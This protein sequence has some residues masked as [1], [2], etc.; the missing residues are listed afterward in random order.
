MTTSGEIKLQAKNRRQES[1]DLGRQLIEFEGGQGGIDILTRFVLNESLMLSNR[2][3][4]IDIALTRGLITIAEI[5]RPGPVPTLVEFGLV[6]DK[7][8]TI[9]PGLIQPDPDDTLLTNH[10]GMAILAALGFLA[11]AVWEWYETRSVLLTLTVTPFL[12][13]ASILIVMVSF[14]ISVMV[15][16]TVLP[17][18]KAYRRYRQAIERHNTLAM[19]HKLKS[20]ERDVRAYSE[21]NGPEFERLVARAFRNRGWQV[22]EMGGAND[23]GIDLVAHK[24]QI[25]AVVQCKAHARQIPPAVVRELYGTFRHSDASVAILAITHGPSE[26]A[27][28][29]AKDKPIRFMSPDDLIIGRGL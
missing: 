21:C 18:A 20:H 19:I 17:G 1:I 2:L 22:E 14:A 11:A 15:I 3:D 9:L 25:R 27:R 6:S 28:V 7:P 13:I 8:P 26:S 4:V 12:S 16:N 10:I 23:G 24:G 29:W 5:A